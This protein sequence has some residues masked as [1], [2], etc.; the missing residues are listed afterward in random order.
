MKFYEIDTALREAIAAAETPARVKIEI[1]MG[2]RFESVFERDVIQAD[3][4]GLKEAAGG[5][6]AR[7]ELLLENPHGVYSI[8]GGAG[9]K[10]RVSFSMGE[11]LPYFRR[12]IF[13][14]DEKGVQ[15]IRG[16]GR[17][18][19]ARLGVRDFSEKLRKADTARDWTA[20][21]V[22]AYSVVVDRNNPATSLVHRVAGRAGLSPADVDCATIPVTLPF[23]RLRRNVWAELS[24]MATAYRCHLECAP[25]GKLLFSHSPYQTDER[26]CSDPYSLTGGDIF[27][28][29]KTERA[30]LYRNTVRLKVN[31]PVSLGRREIWRYDQPPVFYDDNLNARYPFRYPLVREIEAGGYEAN[32]SVCDGRG[33][34]RNVVYADEIDSKEEAERRLEYSGGPFSYSRYDTASGIDKAFLTLRKENDG[35]LYKAAIYGRPIVLDLNRSCFM[36]DSE[37]VSRYG[38]IALNVTG[39]YFSEHDTGGRPHYEDWVIREL[40]ERLRDRREFTV[41]TH[42][43]LF[44]ARVGARV[45]IAAGNETVTGVIQAFS[46]RYRR[47]MA[48]VSMFRILSEC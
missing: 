43:G 45:T 41:K 21:A 8:G 24:S 6:S 40:T 23:V 11:G 25:D 33:G 29:R 1:D 32:Y 14:V 35:D 5:T 3:F 42:R 28:L 18:R 9:R 12:F 20:P 38:T 30:D 17:E 34:K 48:F 26:G 4:Y 22:F 2:G 7:G 13:Y 36:R 39:P 16:P 15:D 19:R 27:Y 37:A 31:M 46:F 44:N 10:V 47:D